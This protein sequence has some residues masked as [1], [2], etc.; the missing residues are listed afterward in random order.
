MITITPIAAFSDNYIWVL[1][2]DGRAVAVDPGAAAPLQDFLT[3]HTLHLDAILVTHHHADHIGGV[4]ELVRPDLPVYGPPNV[5]EVT[6]ALH[7]GDTVSLP[8]FALTL[9]VLAVPGH[10]LDHLAYTGQDML[11][12][13]DTLFACGCG[14]L[15]EGSPQQMLTSLTRLSALPA[16]TRIY[17]AHEYTLAN[18]RFARRVEPDNLALQQRHVRDQARRAQQR[19]TLP[20]TLAEEHDSNPFLRVHCATVRQAVAHHDGMPYLD[21]VD[22]FARLRAWKNAN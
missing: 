19:P 10:T 18:Q 13:G 16:S 2:Q 1:H 11:F 12:C 7:D 22:T 14:R 17:C 15:F 9:S 5:A 3:A 4:A 6:H 20:S 21:D 8:Q